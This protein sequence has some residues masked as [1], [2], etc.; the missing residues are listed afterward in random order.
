MLY[1]ERLKIDT[2][3]GSVEF[4]TFFLDKKKSVYIRTQGVQQ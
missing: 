3:L 1:F 2:P 4:C